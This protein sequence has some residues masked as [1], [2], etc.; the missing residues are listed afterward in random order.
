V[1]AGDLNTF[2]N[3][4]SR[5]LSRDGRATSL[6]KP[7][8]TPEAAWWKVALLPNTGY[9]DPFGA[10]DTTFAVPPLFRAKLDWV[11]V[12]RARVL[13]QGMGIC[14]PSDHLPIWVDL[15]LGEDEPTAWVDRDGTVPA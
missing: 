1:I 11:A 6:G 3:L 15:A 13:N 8:S 14:S 12:K 4:L 9:D 7:A 10:R 2:D 5:L